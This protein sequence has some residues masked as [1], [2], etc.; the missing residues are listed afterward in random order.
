[1][2]VKS[3]LISIF[4]PKTSR[5]V[6]E[7]SNGINLESICTSWKTEEE[8]GATGNYV[9][10]GTFIVDKEGLYKNIVE[11]AI[12]K[13]RI[14]G[15][16]EYFVINKP[17]INTRTVTIT[18][19]HITIREQKQL[20]LNDVRPTNSNGLGTLQHLYSNATG[21]KEI[22][23]SS[24]IPVLATAY[25][26]LMNMYKALY[27]CDQSF[28]NRW[29]GE[30]KRRGYNVTINQK[31]S[32]NSK[33]TIREGKNLTG[34][35]VTTNT[36]TF[37][38]RGI[39]K[40][41]DGIKGDYV[42]SPLIN[43]YARVNT[44]VFEYNDVR[45]RNG[46]EKEEEGYMYFN[47]LEEAKAELNR[48]VALEFSENHVDE[49][50]ATYDIS[51]EQLADTEEYK[52]YAY[53]E[54]AEVG[55]IVKVYVPS[56]DIEVSVR[57]TKKIYNGSTQRTDSMTLSNTT[58]ST[59]LSMASIIADLKKQYIKTGN[60]NMNEYLTSIINAGMQDS[61]VIVRKNEILIMDTADINTAKSVWRFNNGA[62]THT[63]NGYYANDWNIGLTKDGIINADMIRTG[64]LTAIT[65]K[66]VD[67]SFMMD[68]GQSGGC[69]FYSNNQ[70]A[71]RIEGHELDFYNWAKNGDY[72]GSLG[73]TVIT[74]NGQPVPNKCYI[75]LWNDIDSALMLG[76]KKDSTAKVYPYITLDKHN[77]SGFSVNTAPIQVNEKMN[78]RYGATFNTTAELRGINMNDGTGAIDVIGQ[79]VVR[80]NTF[81]QKD[82]QV[83]GNKNCLQQ[84]KQYKKVPFYSVEDINS[85][86]TIT[87]IEEVYK[88]ELNKNTGNY[89]K[90]IDI[91]TLDSYLPS[92]LLADCLNTSIGYNVYIDKMGFGDYYVKKYN[93]YFIVFSDR[94]MEFKFKIEARRTG[95]ED[96]DI[97]KHLEEIERG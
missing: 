68:L 46:D 31:R 81:L 92:D 80:D 57:V 63:N 72:I 27:D 4:P 66:S 10:D 11:E 43:K 24:D 29:G 36:D 34:F 13:V 88:T 39:G 22:T 30:T 12:L 67:G 7:G 8:G 40:G 45:L 41:F 9:L 96:M 38:T 37:C 1:M 77:I 51:F 76:Y 17:K 71:M 26:Q 5:S 20:W 48:R 94:E 86:L 44:Q 78:F 2:I 35:D 16:F 70:L 49:I 6:V 79:F 90:I 87:P 89:C 61:N 73:S 55:D 69:S 25:Y 3:N 33:L 85:L 84:T 65:I 15:R 82:L 56:L 50:Q 62:L 58:T 75:E 83:T 18:A 59:T 28:V 60:D 91:N 32:S 23:L 93:G 42:E 52:D 97:N 19:L 54:V 95:F 47:T 74:E 64:I 21:T 53:L 14:E